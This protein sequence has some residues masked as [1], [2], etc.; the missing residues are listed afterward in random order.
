MANLPGGTMQEFDASIV[1][2]GVNE[3][4]AI[5]ALVEKRV[6]DDYVGHLQKLASAR[7]ETKDDQGLALSEIALDVEGLTGPG[8]GHLREARRLIEQEEFAEALDHVDEALS[9]LAV[10]VAE[11]PGRHEALYHEALYMKALCQFRL[12]QVVE[13]MRTLSSLGARRPSSALRTR[14]GVLREEIRGRIL[15][16]VMLEQLAFMVEGKSNDAISHLRDLCELDPEMPMFH[17]MLAG[18]LM[19]ANR[20]E[21][22]AAAADEGLR[23]CRDDGE[24]GPEDYGGLIV[25]GGIG[26][27][28]SGE[29]PEQRQGDLGSLEEISRQIRRRL[30]LDEM[31][32]AR[33][34][35]LKGKF[36]KARSK[37]AD[38]DADHRQDPVW[39]SFDHYLEEL[40]ALG[41][42]LGRDH[43]AAGV[44]PR[45]TA[46]DL[47]AL[48]FFLVGG[49]IAKG[50]AHL[51]E[52]RPE[53]ADREIDEALKYAPHFP[54]AHLLKAMCLYGRLAKQLASGKA[55]DLD[56]AIAQLEMARER[57]DFAMRDPDLAESDIPGAIEQALDALR[58]LQ[59]DIVQLQPAIEEFNLIMTSVEGGIESREQLEKTA[60]RMKRLRKRVV[61]LEDRVKSDAGGDALTRLNQ[62]V[63]GHCDQLDELRTKVADEAKDVEKDAKMVKALQDK[64]A[65]I[66]QSVQ[67]GVTPSELPEIAR[68]LNALQKEMMGSFSEIQSS[69]GRDALLELASAVTKNIEQIQKL[70]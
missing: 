37:L 66:M 30:L 22:A 59:Q 1:Q 5:S 28:K 68:R 16:V 43:D 33:K 69:A 14:I 7:M 44:Q 17:Y 38:V 52:G 2:A 23:C 18:T 27:P 39:T 12:G 32:P 62:A 61:G 46:E 42:R 29:V 49:E 3:L 58:S 57:A 47:D 11:T 15:P 48:H 8:E 31:K 64:Y 26:E 63:S 9:E 53:A 60:K 24:V 50:K 4:P 51:G 55:P 19:T 67:G 54:Y 65:S 13:A 10:A 36:A 35:Y 25:A 70:S 21:E 45:G 34:Q 6:S 56:V 41:A 40:D 20:L